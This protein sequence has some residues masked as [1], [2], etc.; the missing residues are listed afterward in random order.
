[1]I[2]F[3][4]INYILIIFLSSTILSA[5]KAAAQGTKMVEL[6][7]VVIDPGHGGK[8]PGTIKGKVQEKNITLSVA[9]LLGGMIQEKYPSVKVIYTRSTDKFVPLDQR[10]SIANKNK[11]DL[12]ISIHVNATKAT[13]ARGTETF[14]MGLDKSN[15]NMEVC[16]L[17]NSVLTLEEGYNSK[18]SGFDPKNPESYIIFSLLQNSHLEQSL[19]MAEAVQNE[20]KK[21]P[22]THN[23]GVKQAPFLVLWKCTMPSILVELGFLS[24]P[25]DFKALTSKNSQVQFARGIFK[26]FETYKEQYDTTVEM[27]AISEENPP[28]IG[29]S[30]NGKYRIQIMASSKKIEKGSGEFKGFDCEVVKVGNMYKY[31]VGRFVSR[32]DASK[33]LEKVKNL[34]PSAF[35]SKFE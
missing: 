6:K 29:Y 13:S 31:T 20:F 26:A 2:F 30:P 15:S 21:G 33:E 10:A 28:T 14:V 18:Y 32:D 4:Y 34:F 9:K 22:I 3:R 8:D 5:G 17:E 1:M 27:P 12:F 35:I 11:A 19:I 23:R 24:N 7:T 25:N 16:Q